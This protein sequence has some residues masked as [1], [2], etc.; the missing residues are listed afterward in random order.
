MF[1]IDRAEERIALG[2]DDEDREPEND[3]HQGDWCEATL[4][5]CPFSKDVEVW[6]DGGLVFKA[7]THSAGPSCVLWQGEEWPNPESYSNWDG[8]S[9]GCVVGLTARPIEPWDAKAWNELITGS[10]EWDKE[11]TVLEVTRFAVALAAEVEAEGYIPQEVEED[12]DYQD[13]PLDFVA[14][15]QS[16]TRP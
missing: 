16:R 8:M 10:R 11:R 9:L 2:R 15:P 4:R 13:I 1:I 6:Y 7:W 14:Y 12:E 3:E 5:C